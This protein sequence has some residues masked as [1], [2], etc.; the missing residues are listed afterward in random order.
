MIDDE[1][2]HG[3]STYATASARCGLHHHPAPHPLSLI[4]KLP[5]MSITRTAAN[6]MIDAG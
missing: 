6:F 1:Y 2:V 3:R 4:M 5:A